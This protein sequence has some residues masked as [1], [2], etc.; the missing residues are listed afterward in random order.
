MFVNE[1]TDFVTP[2]SGFT[3]TPYRKPGKVCVN[4][5]Y[6]LADYLAR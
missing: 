3:G 1:S 5:V 4:E 2:C 6:V